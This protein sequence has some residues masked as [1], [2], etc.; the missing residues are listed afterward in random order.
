MF[1]KYVEHIQNNGIELSDKLIYENKI[2]YKKIIMHIGCWKKELS[3]KY[4]D[5]CPDDTIRLSKNLSKDFVLPDSIPYKVR[6]EGRNI[7]L[8]PVIGLLFVTKHKTL[9]P[10][11]LSAYNCYLLNYTDVK[12]LVFIGSSEGINTENHTIKGYFYL[13]DSDEPWKE[14]IF[15]YPDAMYRRV[16][17]SGKKYEDLIMHMGDRIFN[18]YFFNKWELWQCL[19]P[20]EEIRPHLPY[21]EK[22]TGI[23]V[24][25]KMLDQY[26]SVYLKKI[27]GE[28][29]IGIYRVKKLD[30]GYEFIDRI[31][32]NHV[33]TSIEEV[34]NFIEGITR[35][36]GSYIVQQAIE[37]KRIE[38]RSFDMRVVLQKDENKKWS[39]TSMIARFGGTGS[40]TSN[41]GLNGMAKRGNEAF[42]QIFNL[43]E[44]DAA[45]MEKDII[46]VCS[47][48]CETLNKSIGHY[49][50]LGIDV[51]IDENQKVWIL[52]INKLHYH[53]YPVYA[54]KDRQMYHD[55]ASKPIK[56]AC[57]LAGFSNHLKAGY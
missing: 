42:M 34:S 38:N 50:D 26:N 14:G 49:G 17:I 4:I 12:G 32:K 22:L 45:T 19:S 28:K 6:F 27:F 44:E 18:T 24:L 15:P 43:S 53:P 11:F 46:N 25:I 36:Y 2:I 31:R 1:I 16:G 39:C 20:Y 7:Y 13:P 37:G 51:V 29:S 33:F 23:D 48:A 55:I 21:T 5:D 56:Y 10:K 54:L 47:K 8:G 9:T 41:I 30:N 52:E 35:K 3:V 57:A 40:I